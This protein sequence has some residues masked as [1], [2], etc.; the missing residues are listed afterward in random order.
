MLFHKMEIIGQSLLEY[1]DGNINALQFYTGSKK[2]K[3]SSWKSLE[4]MPNSAK[5]CRVISKM[6]PKQQLW[7][8]G[9]SHHMMF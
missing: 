6:F 5:K 9:R 2:K 7:P 3:K 4:I 1:Y 8:D